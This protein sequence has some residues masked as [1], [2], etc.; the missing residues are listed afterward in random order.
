MKY[1]LPSNPVDWKEVFRSD[2]AADLSEMYDWMQ[3]G[4]L[5]AIIKSCAA[6]SFGHGG[7]TFIVSPSTEAEYAYRI[8][9]FDDLG[10][11]YHENY[12]S[13]GDLIKNGL[14]SRVYKGKEII[15]C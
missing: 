3:T 15:T 14:H 2:K 6:L 1:I 10:A 4:I 8:T 13:I 7:Y 5:T 12:T 9:C 11:A